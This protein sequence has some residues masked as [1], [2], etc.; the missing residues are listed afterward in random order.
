[1]PL[2]HTSNLQPFW[3]RKKKRLSV[4]KQKRGHI[5]KTKIVF[6]G[7]M[8]LMLGFVAT[9]GATTYSFQLSPTNFDN[10]DHNNS[11][12]SGIDWSV[13]DN[14][15]TWGID[16]SVP[17]NEAITGASLSFLNIKNWNDHTNDLWVTLFPSATP[18]VVTGTDNPGVGN[19]FSGQGILLNHW[20]DR[21]FFRPQ[22]TTYLLSPSELAYL[23]TYI[24]DGNIGLGFDPDCHYYIDGITLTVETHA[25][26]THAA[27]EPAT[28]LLLGTGLVGLAGFKRKFWKK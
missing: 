18:G 5:L 13:P 6:L 11:Y 16:W 21:P 15:Y 2:A 8:I 12:T 4:E 28:L 10:L 20:Q 26:E 3:A 27:P 14:F 1:M 22:D 7:F 23:S 19:D 24:S 9:V 25:V 17:A